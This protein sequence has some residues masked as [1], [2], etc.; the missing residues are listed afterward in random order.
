MPSVPPA[1]RVRALQRAGYRCEIVTRGRE[2]PRTTGRAIYVD[3]EVKV[4]CLAHQ[5][6]LAGTDDYDWTPK[7]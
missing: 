7:G 2:C 5:H 1:V 4:V 6:M 3:G